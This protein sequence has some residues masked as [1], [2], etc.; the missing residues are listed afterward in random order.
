MNAGAAPSR[1]N[2][3]PRE[4]AGVAGS[5]IAWRRLPMLVLVCAVALFVL[6]QG[7]TTM[8]ADLASQGARR[9]VGHWVSHASAVPAPAELA[10]ARAALLTSLALTPGNAALHEQLGDLALMASRLPNDDDAAARTEA[11][12]AAARHYRD[13]LALQPRDPQTWASLSLALQAAG[14]AASA[15]DAWHEALRRGPHEGHVQPVLLEVLLLDWPGATPD[16]QDWATTLFRQAGPR[17]RLAMNRAAERHG[18]HFELDEPQEV[19]PTPQTSES[20]N[21]ER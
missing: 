3:A 5:P 10:Q 4:G 11:L 1:S 15:Q 9:L 17:E 12:R 19:P 2:P 13:A 6:A 20:A 7:L 8:A 16:M 14:D 18:L 21:V